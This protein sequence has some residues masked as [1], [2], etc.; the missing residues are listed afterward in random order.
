[1]MKPSKF[2]CYLY[3]SNT[4]KARNSSV[5]CTPATR[6]LLLCLLCLSWTGKSADA[7]LTV[8]RELML[9]TSLPAVPERDFENQLTLLAGTA[10]GSPGADA[11]AGLTRAGLE[12]SRCCLRI[13]LTVLRE[14][15]LTPA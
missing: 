9:T 11:D 14:L 6:E 2:F 1:M 3:A 5:T 13:L 15:M 10:Y 4:R 12:I 7:L 8:P